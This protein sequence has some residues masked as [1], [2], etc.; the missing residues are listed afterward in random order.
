MEPVMNAMNS[1][2][3][4]ATDANALNDIKL[5][6]QRDPNGAL[7]DAARQFEAVFMNMLLKSM[8]EATPKD[9]L[10]DS[11]QS[12]FYTSMFD[13]QL[14]QTL[15]KRGLGLADAMVKQ[16]EQARGVTQAPGAAIPMKPLA[17]F[18]PAP[19]S[20]AAPVPVTAPAPAA[21][22]L[23]MPL[24]TPE[25]VRAVYDVPEPEYIHA[26][27]NRKFV[28]AA[29]AEAKS[30][31]G[32]VQAAQPRSTAA[33]SSATQPDSQ[34]VGGP[35]DFVRRMWPHAVEASRATGIPAKFILGQAA[36]ESGWGQ[37][38]IR[39]LDG[40]PSFNVFGIKAGGGWPGGVART[41]TVEYINGVPQQLAQDFRSYNSYADSF[42]DYAMLLKNSPRYAAVVQNSGDAVTFARGL[43][44][45]GYATDP[46]YAN[47]LAQVIG[48]SVFRQATA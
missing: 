41:M 13:Q 23:P 37:R 46:Q 11:E 32:A 26:P 33:A 17:Q 45:A 44:R 6:A 24:P 2:N 38:E 19:A 12:R 36:L 35:S 7:K 14:S 47:K 21:A 5:R 27:V 40:K 30:A 15:A 48:S 20:V 1:M 42:R 4:L 16:I 3:A 31:Q 43:Q 34:K 9:G 29:I 22:Q 39:G 10:M 8:R 18:M 28:D 25:P